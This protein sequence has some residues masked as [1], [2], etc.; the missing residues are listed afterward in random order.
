MKFQ[1]LDCKKTFVYA[2]KKTEHSP[3]L[4]VNSTNFLYDATANATNMPISQE[5]TSIETHVCP[6][7]HS[8]NIDEVPPVKEQIASVKSVDLANVD[9]YLKEGYV[10]HALYAK[11]AVLTKIVAAKLS[12]EKK[13]R[14]L[15]DE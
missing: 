8:L 12:G 10:V 9:E 1:C 4:T 13:P 3:I 6:H 7:C 15:K 2:T 5:P 14:M 11:T